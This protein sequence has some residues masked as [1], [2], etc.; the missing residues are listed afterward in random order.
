[1][2]EPASIDEAYV[3][4]TGTELMYREPLRDTA[5]RIQRAVLDETGI[6]VSIGGAPTKLVAKLAVKRAKPGGVHVVA[7]SDVLAFMRG[8]TLADIPGIGP[9]FAAKL[10]ELGLVSVEDALRRDETTLEQWLGNGRGEW[11]HRKIRGI[12]ESDVHAGRVARS[13]SREETFATDIDDDDAL[14]TEL[15][16][17]AIHL[18]AD[19]RA[20][21]LRA[22]TITVKLRD[23]DFTTR[24]AAHTVDRKSVV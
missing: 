12:D 5:L 22:R 20:S 2:V 17:L 11:L 24:T 14:E 10:C 8:I 6:I 9:V 3:D 1:M 18:G 21:R 4:L 23:A 16:G 19:V 15:L 13:M 7:E